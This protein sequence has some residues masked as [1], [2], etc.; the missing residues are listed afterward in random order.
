M[1]FLLLPKQ[2]FKLT[3]SLDMDIYLPYEVF[4]FLYLSSVS[5]WYSAY[6]FIK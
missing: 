5:F 4:Q 1:N 6:I 2:L 3:K